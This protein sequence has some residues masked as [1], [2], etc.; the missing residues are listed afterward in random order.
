MVDGLLG[1]QNP[2][3]RS[4]REVLAALAAM[5]AA[6]LLPAGAALAAGRGA[7][8]ADRRPSPFLLARLEEGRGR[9]GRAQATRSPF[10]ANMDWT[11]EKSLED[12]EKGGVTQAVLS[13]ASIPDNWFGGDPERPPTWR[14]S[15]TSYGAGLVRDN[16]GTFGSIASLPMI[17]VDASLKEIEYALDTLKADGIG[18]CDQLWRQMAGRRDV[19]ADLRG[20]Q[21]AQGGGLFP[22]DHAQLLRQ[23]HPRGR[24]RCGARSAVR[25]QPRGGEPA[26]L[27]HAS[28]GYRDIRWVFAHSGGSLPSLAG[29]I[30]R[31]H[32]AAQGPQG[33]RAERRR[34]PS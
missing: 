13:L 20:A 29:R 34:W 16:P 17:D 21:P 27:G 9:L 32:G 10:P 4:R 1:E 18:L 14:M 22:S 33:F 3:R 11:I 25:H 2:E 19:Q 23:P 8:A 31:L 24:R 15:A 28:R 5:G 6:A 12:M 26:G 7:D 30:E